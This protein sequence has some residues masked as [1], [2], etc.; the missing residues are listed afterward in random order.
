MAVGIVAL[1]ATIVESARA[2][3][4][5]STVATVTRD[6]ARVSR[7]VARTL[8]D[9]DLAEPERTARLEA[10]TRER[11][12][13]LVAADR[14]PVRHGWTLASAVTRTATFALCVAAVIAALRRRGESAPLSLRRRPT[15]PGP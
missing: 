5:R 9:R 14:S 13:A 6:T 2:L 3:V 10:L 11:R 7:E 8:A 4:E 1:T 15:R 12:D